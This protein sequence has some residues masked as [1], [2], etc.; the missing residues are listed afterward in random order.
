MNETATHKVRNIFVGSHA[1]ADGFRLIGFEILTDPDRQQ[2][3]QLLNELQRERQR[4][5]LIIEQSVNHMGSKLL[6]QIRREGGRIILSEVPSLHHPDEFHSELDAQL[7]KL[8][9]G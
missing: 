9:G 3:D 1:L 2:L 6:E 8:T 5:L 4:T 7:K